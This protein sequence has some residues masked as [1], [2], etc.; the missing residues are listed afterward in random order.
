MLVPLYIAL[1]TIF[2]GLIALAL[3]SHSVQ[4][5]AVVEELERLQDRL[6]RREARLREMRDELE[7]LA[8]DIELLDLDKRSLEAREACMEK[9]DRFE[10]TEGAD[11]GEDS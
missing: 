11:A 1:L 4:R 10:A 8:V 5:G 2:G 3:V 6:A 7:E 9:L